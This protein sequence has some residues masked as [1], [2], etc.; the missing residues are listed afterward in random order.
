MKGM[1]RAILVGG[2]MVAAQAAMA[3]SSAFPGSADDAGY[4][5]AR[6]TYA[7]QHANDR[8]T[9][10]DSAFPGSVDDA[11]VHLT[12]PITYADQH[13]NDRVTSVDSAFPGSA[14]DEGVHLTARST[15]ADSHLGRQA[16]LS[17][18]AQGG[19]TGAN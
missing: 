9:S 17:Q 13:A 18:P 12:A 8:V 10:V 5:T 7:D 6:I 16:R 15:Y 3:D 14:D 4:L 11:G 1:A 19:G 2:F